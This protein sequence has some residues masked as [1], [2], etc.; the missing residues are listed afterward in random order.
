VADQPRAETTEAERRA[1]AAFGKMLIKIA[2]AACRR[3]GDAGRIYLGQG[4]W[5]RCPDCRGYRQAPRGRVG[6][7]RLLNAG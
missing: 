4:I 3:C 7:R 2:A 5:W 1:L 6:R